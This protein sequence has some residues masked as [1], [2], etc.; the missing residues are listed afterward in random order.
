MPSTLAFPCKR[1]GCKALITMRPE[2]P[3]DIQGRTFDC[4]S[5][6]SEFTIDLNE[7]RTIDLRGFDADARDK[8]G[9]RP[10]HIACHLKTATHDGA[11]GEY[12]LGYFRVSSAR[13]ALDLSTPHSPVSGGSVAEMLAQIRSSL[14]SI[15]WND[16]EEVESYIVMVHECFHLYQDLYLGCATYFDLITDQ[17]NATLLSSVRSLVRRGNIRIPIDN[18][19]VL[20]EPERKKADLL[21]VI[22]EQGRR[23]RDHGFIWSPE[24]TKRWIELNAHDASSQ[25]REMMAR[26]DPASLLEGQAAIAT[27]TTVQGLKRKHDLTTRSQEFLKQFKHLYDIDLLPR[28]YNAAY[29]LVETLL[30]LFGGPEDRHYLTMILADIALDIPPP[31]IIDNLQRQGVKLLNFNPAIRF[32]QAIA[33][34]QSMNPKEAASIREAESLAALYQ[35]IDRVIAGKLQVPTHEQMTEYWID[36]LSRDRENTRYAYRREAMMHRRKHPDV[37]LRVDPPNFGALEYMPLFVQ[38]IDGVHSRFSPSL[39]DRGYGELRGGE[40]E[41]KL[42]R[43]DLMIKE[44]D[45]V[46]A[47]AIFTTGRVVCSLADRCPV[48]IESCKRPEGFVM[49]CLPDSDRCYLRLRLKGFQISPSDLETQLDER[50]QN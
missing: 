14:G 49:E 39:K 42:L 28:E 27:M 24:T 1:H 40:E 7:V 36:W 9:Q 18:W 45:D 6:E 11:R 44:A 29:Q 20:N 33:V 46:V 21:D 13:L 31:E 2:R 41:M 23:Y 26:I 22:S 19:S 30:P 47:R 25:M 38:G 5:C 4:P 43:T 37:L 16:A 8:V 50:T 10:G 15:D 48:A 34:L 12:R 32:I 35:A 17:A 3:S